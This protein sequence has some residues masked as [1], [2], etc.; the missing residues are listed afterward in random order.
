MTRTILAIVIA[1]ISFASIGLEPERAHGQNIIQPVSY[2]PQ[3]WIIP[4]HIGG[5]R[6]FG[7]HGPEIWLNVSLYIKPQARNQVWARVEMWARETK[8]DWTEAYEVQHVPV[9]TFARPLNGIV[10]PTQLPFRFRDQYGR[11]W[12]VHYVDTNWDVD[13]IGNPCACGLLNRVSF[14]GD[15]RGDEAGTRTGVLLEFNPIQAF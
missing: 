11:F 13:T 15:T 9:A 5:D 14:I 6:E 2:A 1:T 8:G 4:R 10:A 7:G 3:R 12:A